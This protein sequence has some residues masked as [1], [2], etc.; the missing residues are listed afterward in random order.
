[1][2]ELNNGKGK[3]A[4]ASEKGQDPCRAVKPMMMMMM[5]SVLVSCITDCI[6]YSTDFCYLQ[7]IYVSNPK[8][9]VL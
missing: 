6:F 2:E 8:V 4:E 1:L 3:L 9:L 7:A 5:A